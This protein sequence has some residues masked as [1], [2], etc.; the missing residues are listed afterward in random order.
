LFAQPEESPMN[1]SS[2]TAQELNSRT[3]DGIHVQLLWRAGDDYLFVTVTDSKRGETLCV[4]V[5]DHSRALDVFNHPF[6]W[7]AHY[8]VVATAT[9]VD[10][11]VSASLSS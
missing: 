6:A 11:P 4:E 5:R 3:N 2:A 7:A 1:M 10:A 8:G 9:P